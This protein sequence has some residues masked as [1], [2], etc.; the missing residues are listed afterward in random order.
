MT[1]DPSRNPLRS[2]PP[3]VT[4]GK[5]IDEVIDQLSAIVEWSIANDSRLGYFA[6]L[7]RKV[8]LTVRERAAQSSFEDG[9]RL[10]SLTV[11]FANRYL[12]AFAAHAAGKPVTRV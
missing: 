9:A 2:I 8:T 7:Y 10:A 5:T 4:S 11:T 3:I 12:A 6:A 1:P